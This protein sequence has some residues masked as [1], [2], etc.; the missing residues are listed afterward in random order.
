MSALARRDFAVV[1]DVIADEVEQFE[2]GFDGTRLELLGGVHFV[3]GDTEEVSELHSEGG[4]VGCVRHKISTHIKLAFL[5]EKSSGKPLLVNYS[6]PYT[7]HMGFRTHEEEGA[8]DTMSLDEYLV[9]NK[10]ATFMFRAKGDH[11]KDSGILRGDLLI[12]DRSK[13]PKTHDIVVAVSHGAFILDYMYALSGRE[14]IVE[15]VVTAVIRKY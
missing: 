10:E 4:E 15:A 7:I 8:L 11:L 9:E 1:F 6:S 3:V 13:E 12:V 5:E 14:A 2:T